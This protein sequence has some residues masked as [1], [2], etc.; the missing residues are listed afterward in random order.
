MLFMI[1]KNPRN[2]LYF[3]CLP[4]FESKHELVSP[5]INRC[6]SKQLKLSLS[7]S[8]KMSKKKSLLTYLIQNTIQ[9][10]HEKYAKLLV[11]F[12]NNTN[13]VSN[14]TINYE[15]LIEKNTKFKVS[16][17]KLKNFNWS[18]VQSFK[19]A[20]PNVAVLQNSYKQVL[21]VYPNVFIRKNKAKPVLVLARKVSLFLNSY[22]QGSKGLF[23]KTSR[24]SIACGFSLQGVATGNLNPQ[25]RAKLGGH[26]S[27]SSFYQKDG[28]SSSFV[29][30][31]E[32]GKEYKKLNL[33]R[34]L[35]SSYSKL[36]E[37]KLIN[38]GLASSQ[39]IK[40]WS[41][42]T[43]P[44]GKIIGQITNANTLH[45]KTL[46]PQK[47]GLF[48]ERIFGPLKDFECACGKNQRPNE[49]KQQKIFEHQQ[50]DR[51]FCPKCDVEYTWSVI[52]RYQLG[53]I[54]LV[55]PVTHAWY[56]KATPSYLSILFDIKKRHLE[57]IV[58]SSETMTLEY[59]QKLTEQQYNSPANLFKMWQKSIENSNKTPKKFYK[60]KKSTSFELTEEERIKFK[61]KIN[62]IKPKRWKAW[63]DFVHNLYD[64]NFNNLMSKNIKI[65]YKI[66]K[67][68]ETL[69]FKSLP[70]M[71]YIITKIQT[72][73]LK[74]SFIFLNDELLIQFYTK[75]YRVAYQKISKY[76]KNKNKNFWLIGN[77]ELK[78]TT[79]FIKIVRQLHHS[80][81][82]INENF[83]KQR[84]QK[85]LFYKKFLY[86]LLNKTKFF[87]NK[88]L[89]LSNESNFLK[90]NFL[91]KIKAS[92]KF[93]S[94]LKLQ[95]SFLR[96]KLINNKL[97][98]FLI[99]KT[100]CFQSKA[101][102]IAFFL[103]K[104]PGSTFGLF[105][106]GR[107][108]SSFLG[109]YR[110]MKGQ[111]STLL[112]QVKG[113]YLPEKTIKKSD[114][115]G[116]F[117]NKILT[118]STLSPESDVNGIYSYCLTI[119]QIG[120]LLSQSITNVLLNKMNQVINT[121]SGQIFKSL[122]KHKLSNNFFPASV[123]KH[124]QQAIRVAPDVLL[125]KN[126]DKQAKLVS[127][128]V[129]KHQHLE[130][131][132]LTMSRA[133]NFYNDNKKLQLFFTEFKSNQ[134]MFI[135]N[136]F[137]VKERL[138]DENSKNLSTAFE[139]KSFSLFNN[140]AI[141]NNIYCLSHRY[142]W[143]IE[144]DWKQF[145]DYLGSIPDLNDNPIVNYKARIKNSQN[146]VN[147]TGITGTILI[148]KLLQ[149]FNFTELKKIDKQNRILLYELNKNLIRLKKSLK[150]SYGDRHK[151][152]VF[153]ELYKKRDALIRRTKLIRKLFRKDSTPASMILSI[154]PVLPPDLRPII[155]VGGQIAA[156]DL[157]RLYQR[158]IYR[159]ERLKKFLKDPATINSYEMKYAQRLLQEA[160]DNL[161]QNGNS[162]L[163]AEKDSKGRVLKSLSDVL[164]GK[165]GR[166]RQHLLGKRVDYSGRSVIVVGPK[167]KLYECGLPKEMALELFLPFMIK[168]I[169]S[170]KL[171]RTVIGA[172]TLIKNNKELTYDILRE[173]MIN[174]PILLNRAPT[175]HR[176]G[177]QAF[178]PKLVEGRAIL[179]H[180]L[181]CPAFN[182]DF[183][184][185]QMAVHVPIT[186]EARAE[187]WKLMF[188]R[189]NLLSPA[190]GDPI[191]LPS[192]DMVLG[193]Y[194]LTTENFKANLTEQIYF[195]NFLEV[196][197]AYQQ[198]RITTHTIVWVR[199][200]K[201]VETG[202]EKE[203]PIEIRINKYGYWQEIYKKILIRYD[204]KSEKVSQFIKTT[205]G[206]ILFNELIR[207]STKARNTLL[208]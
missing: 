5:R 194:Y 2:Y 132:F 78:T 204:F 86:K 88:N 6:V 159:N 61:I 79:S 116:F 12:C 48:C 177:I 148:Q 166:F 144:K 122:I 90:Q 59:S 99:K 195:S 156:S 15:K 186:V 188:S 98:L 157:N 118:N 7:L 89:T 138:Y 77:N 73:S 147:E 139:G 45:H 164:K 134:I 69:N 82:K 46:K 104:K 26:A 140:K 28:Q 109:E 96:K 93:F 64:K 115:T 111:I 151:K 128:Y 84:C 60:K 70:I 178:Q 56:L 154:L 19:Q 199:Y 171:A 85:T 39:R 35:S 25:K 184:G 54:Q 74:K 50:L 141:H 3:I 129:D 201:L 32:D 192:Q 110:P 158:V 52:R 101:E 97:I 127:I 155:K 27:E 189:N 9:E 29:T 173:I 206:R 105:V 102:A 108:L 117:T 87:K 191:V 63:R 121:E 143:S 190:T 103:R 13:V 152:K 169:I 205:A 182:A 80:S 125:T 57:Y 65:Y 18:S 196:L 208:N 51:L 168:K 149:D 91:K 179:L 145:I 124:E 94:F 130:P 62:N 120:F 53:Y 207:N 142:R 106:E 24:I 126:L 163:T 181:V 14:N 107:V 55:S 43:L 136:L 187:S 76:L 23:T 198:A 36:H 160:V 112:Y 95:L 4:S 17:N 170:L 119:N 31:S 183:D 176:L 30:I 68:L 162:G 8:K 10:N 123:K 100:F 47:G 20:V 81:V 75:I 165:Q 172:K 37:L 40:Q 180:P 137:F 72:L 150:K 71:I 1:N 200:K 167:L 185:D 66:T 34:D 49:D 21:L 38:I 11:K 16:M 197:K 83:A 113:S 202:A 22:G 203:Q 33:K 67:N 174:H 193:C 153:K 58:Y 42:K 161:I 114:T 44:N 131:I 135:N 133:F 41:E 92:N 146:L 175:L